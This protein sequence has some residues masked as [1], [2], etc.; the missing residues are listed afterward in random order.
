METQ[1]KQAHSFSMTACLNLAVVKKC[2]LCFL[3]NLK[4]HSRVDS[5]VFS[6]SVRASIQL[7]FRVL[8]TLDSNSKTP[9][10]GLDL[11]QSVERFM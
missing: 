8:R 11:A 6:L 3:V 1:R 10:S 4:F 5:L 9:P 7:T 2:F